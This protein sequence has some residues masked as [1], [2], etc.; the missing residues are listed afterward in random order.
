MLNA[1]E[2]R[3]MELFDGRNLVDT[4]CCHGHDFELRKNLLCTLGHKLKIYPQKIQVP[5]GYQ[6]TL[7]PAPLV[8]EGDRQDCDPM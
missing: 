1:R 3:R 6:V 2:R 7:V 4:K 5:I 8:R